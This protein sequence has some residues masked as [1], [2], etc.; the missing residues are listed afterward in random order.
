MDQENVAGWYLFFNSV[1]LTWG[2]VGSL[3][4]RHPARSGNIF[5]FHKCGEGVTGI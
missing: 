1:V 4:R 5:E 2:H 3:P